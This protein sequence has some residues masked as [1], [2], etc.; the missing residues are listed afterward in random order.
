ME[1]E[2]YI[3]GFHR[4]HTYIIRYASS[5]RTLIL[6]VCIG[7]CTCTYVYVYTYM[8]LQAK[9]IRPP[10]LCMYTIS[11]LLCT[12]SQTE[13]RDVEVSVSTRTFK[14]H[15]QTETAPLSMAMDRSPLLAKVNY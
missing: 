15:R 6:S 12:H 9:Q 8:F 14:L 3:P 1:E 10:R 13:K 7:M 4:I 5:R 2:V 11:I